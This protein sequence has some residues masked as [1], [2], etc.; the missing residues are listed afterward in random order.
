M[1]WCGAAVERQ[2]QRAFGALGA[3][4]ASRPLLVSLSCLGVLAALGAGGFGGGVST[5]TDVFELWV[6]QG[7]R[8]M[9]EMDFY[10]E[11]WSGSRVQSLI[12]TCNDEAGEPCA[13][14]SVEAL[15]ELANLTD[16]LLRLEYTPPTLKS[17][18]TYPP[19]TFESICY[20]VGTAEEDN[21]TEQT[22]ALH[23][24]KRTDAGVV[25]QERGWNCG[26]RRWAPQRA[27]APACRQATRSAPSSAASAPSPPPQKKTQ[28]LRPL[29]QLVS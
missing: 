29:P 24:T 2:L 13:L 14:L 11:E 15:G 16:W 21:A 25:S 6:E 18:K 12:A 23:Q 22:R 9:N 7:T 20:K 8:L 3:L 4:V 27:A 17:G 10:E 28:S 5:E 1:A 26:R 19:F